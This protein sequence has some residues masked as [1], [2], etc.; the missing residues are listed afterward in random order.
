M[1]CMYYLVN[2]KTN[3]VEAKIKGQSKY[4]VDLIRAPLID[5]APEELKGS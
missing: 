5:K 4:A 3:V 1:S 2:L